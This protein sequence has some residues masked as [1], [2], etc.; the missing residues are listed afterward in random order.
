MNLTLVR[1]N[2]GSSIINTLIW[3]SILI[4]SCDIVLAF[5]VAGL[6]VRI[7]Q[8]V[9]MSVM[10]LFLLRI[11]KFGN[12]KIL[13]PY[14]NLLIVIVFNTI[15]IFNSKTIF[16]AV[17]Y[18]L[19]LIFDCIQVLAFTYFLSK[20]ESV[21]SIVRK[22]IMCFNALAVVGFVQF[23]LQF[24]GINFFV[25][26]YNDLHRSNG[27]SYEPSFYATYM[28]MGSIICLY[29][30]ERR[31]YKCM[32]KSALIISTLLNCG[33]VVISTSRMGILILLVYIVYR[34]FM[35]LRIYI[36]M[37]ASLIRI[38]FTLMPIMVG[39]ALIFLIIA[40]EF[41]VDFVMH[42]LSG[43]GIGG[44]TSHSADARMSGFVDTWKLFLDSP[45]LGCSLGGI[46]A[47]II[48]YKARNY[49][50]A[51]NGGAS[52]CISLEALA[53]YGIFG[54]FFFFK[55]MWDLTVGGYLKA[56]KRPGDKKDRE[57]V[58]AMLIALFFEFVILQLN[59]NVLRPPF[60][61]HIALVSTVL[62][63]YLRDSHKYYMNKT[64]AE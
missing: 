15:C 14:Y 6:T 17:G 47:G 39:I 60:W 32:R 41:E 62:Q 25:T 29:L 20:Q 45:F 31:N 26:Q 34:G 35:S 55:Y 3:I 18:D 63:I 61:V 64:E 10:F 21:H 1:M 37:R 43:L 44:T 22:Y 23:A 16:N 24:V 46:D 42:Y 36:H 51:N 54:A 49:T 13:T 58:Y 12:V 50:V 59:Q 8:L 48:E 2:K 27:F 9:S 40:I 53:A 11:I 56:K 28:I 7:S 38:L 4:A 33:A 5:E 52:M 19:W 30:L 57:P